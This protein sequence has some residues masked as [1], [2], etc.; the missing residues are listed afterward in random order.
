M[1]KTIISL[2]MALAAV[3]ANLVSCGGDPLKENE[4]IPLPENPP[5]E[6]ETGKACKLVTYGK[7]RRP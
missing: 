6:E 3:L 4:N 7:F 2:L 1:S 5:V